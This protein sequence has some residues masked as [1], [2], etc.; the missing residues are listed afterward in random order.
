MIGKREKRERVRERRTISV[1][2][3][4]IH[5]PVEA[6]RSS[7]PATTSRII[8]DHRHACIRVIRQ[9]IRIIRAVL[10]THVCVVHT[11]RYADAGVGRFGLVTHKWKSSK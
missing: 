1:G 3:T 10:Q 8:A 11:S 9:V 6:V 7:V 5:I 4:E 2:L